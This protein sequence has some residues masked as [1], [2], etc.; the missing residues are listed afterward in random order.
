M[1]RQSAVALAV[2]SIAGMVIA[3]EAS[4]NTYGPS[5]NNNL[6]FPDD[7]NH[8]FTYVGLEP[9][10]DQAANWARVEALGNG[11]NMTEE[12]VG[13]T[14]SYIDVFVYDEY[15]GGTQ[16]GFYQCVSRHPS[17]NCDTSDVVMNN[18]VLNSQSQNNKTKTACHEIGHS[19]GLGHTS[20]TDSC[21]IEGSSENIRFSDH[22]KNHINGRF[23]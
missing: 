14:A 21:M 13:G 6:P 2:V 10:Y 9:A 5:E 17:G 19:V 23:P 12:Y 20:L 8:T 18:S 16:R 15:Y 4:A 11:T 1:I 7:R 22:D 3:T